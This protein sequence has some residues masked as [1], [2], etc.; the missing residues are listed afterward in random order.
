MIEN[1]IDIT[2]LLDAWNLRRQCQDQEKDL[3]TLMMTALKLLLVQLV[4]PIYSFCVL[5]KIFLQLK[6]FQDM[7][8]FQVFNK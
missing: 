6:I 8:M 4:L 3:V 2:L 5:L 1:N 7:K